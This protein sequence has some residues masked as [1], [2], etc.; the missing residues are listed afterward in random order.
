VARGQAPAP[1]P[2]HDLEAE[3]MAEAWRRGELTVRDVL[4][5]L[6]R[7]EKQRAYTTYMTIM[8]RLARKGMLERR[9]EGKTDFYRPRFGEEEYRRLRAG[10][11]VEALVEEFGDAALI[12]F[13]REMAKLDPRRREQLRRLAR[14]A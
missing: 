10:A 13:A 1:P 9:R 12:H 5:A 7:G 8:G 3:V 14:R 6:N 2:L 11:E 4:Q